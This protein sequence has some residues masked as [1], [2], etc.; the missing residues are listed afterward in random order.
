M[1]AEIILKSEEKEL[2]LHQNNSGK[3]SRPL[4]PY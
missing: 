1:E 2:L 4:C 3:L